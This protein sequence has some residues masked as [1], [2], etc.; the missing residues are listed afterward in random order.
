MYCVFDRST[1]KV[2]ESGF[3][4]RQT[5]KELRGKLNSEYYPKDQY[6]ELKLINGDFRYIVARDESHPNGFSNY[7]TSFVPSKKTAKVEEAVEVIEETPEEK[8]KRKVA[9]KLEK[10]AKKDLKSA[11]KEKKHVN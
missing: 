6:I 1:E 8:K 5:A 11:N 7:E 10:Q 4:T 2:I 3:R 9:E